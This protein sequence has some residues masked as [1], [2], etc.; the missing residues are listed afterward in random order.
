MI[1]GRNSFRS[2]V[3]VA[4]LLG[5]SLSVIAAMLINVQTSALTWDSAP[6][7]TYRIMSNTNLLINEW[8][9]ICTNTATGELSTWQYS[10]DTDE[11]F[12]RLQIEQP[13]GFD[14]VDPDEIVGYAKA[15]VIKNEANTS[16]MSAVANNFIPNTNSIDVLIGDQLPPLSSIFLWKNNQWTVSSRNVRGTWNNQV[17]IDLGQAFFIRLPSDAPYGTNTLYMSGRVLTDASHP[18]RVDEYV[19]FTGLGYPVHTDLLNT[20]LASELPMLS[21]LYIFNNEAAV[22]RSSSKNARSGWNYSP[23]P[24]NPTSAFWINIPSTS[25]FTCYIT[26]PFTY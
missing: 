3:T 13:G 10:P 17:T 12:F 14:Y 6:G 16:G 18:I 9:A 5:S 19:S 22:Y 1:A 11:K 4:L 20:E 8:Q 2:A 7:V 21:S 24:A 15:Y 23:M 26:R 25:S